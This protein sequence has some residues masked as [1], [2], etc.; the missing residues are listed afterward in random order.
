M[1]GKERMGI[2]FILVALPSGISHV[3][4]ELYR[5]D[6]LLSPIIMRYIWIAS[7]FALGGF[8]IA[9]KSFTKGGI[10]GS[11]LVMVLGPIAVLTILL[12]GMWHKI[13]PLKKEV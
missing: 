7:A 11:L 13:S 4:C 6:L 9:T 3:W 1:T 2:C 8:M 12:W 10:V 5:P